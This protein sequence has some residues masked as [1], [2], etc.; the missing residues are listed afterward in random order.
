MYLLVHSVIAGVAKHS[1][2]T[3]GFNFLAELFVVDAIES[4][5]CGFPV[6]VLSA[7]IDR[8]GPILKCVEI[9]YA[10]SFKAL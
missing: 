7:I 2:T 4:I 9:F 5:G 3:S 1:K 10:V 8:A 6:T